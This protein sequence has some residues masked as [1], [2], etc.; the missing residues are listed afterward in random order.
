MAFFDW[1]ETELFLRF[2]GRKSIR[3]KNS[4][5]AFLAG[6]LQGRQALFIVVQTSNNATVGVCIC[7]LQVVSGYSNY[8]PCYQVN[9]T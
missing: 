5:A 1:S 8:S 3:E 2:C 6:V 4:P 9:S 7:C